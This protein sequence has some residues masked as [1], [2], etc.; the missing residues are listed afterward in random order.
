[1][2]LLRAIDRGG[3]RP[4]GGKEVKQPDFR[5]IAATSSDLK[6]L[7]ERGRM[8]EDFFYR[9]HIIPISL[10]PLRERKE[11]IPHLVEH[12]LEQYEP[13]K[14]PVMDGKIL[15]A[16]LRYDWPGNVR[17]LQNTLHRYATLDKID[18]MN[19]DPARSNGARA[20]S[21]VGM[22][23][24]NPTLRAVLQSVEKRLIVDAL[25]KTRWRKGKAAKMLDVDPK[26]LFRKI[27]Q[28]RLK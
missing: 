6:D 21:E 2:K 12:F 24:E 22:D 15:D 23:E 3:F 26:T 18:F 9:I 1:M 16:L 5:I 11:D 8:R 10:P 14:R 27:K 25:D 7:V 4:V 17:E 28:H 13:D 20:V 19:A